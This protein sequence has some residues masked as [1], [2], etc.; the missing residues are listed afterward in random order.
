MSAL[1]HADLTRNQRRSLDRLKANLDRIRRDLTAWQD[2]LG[3]VSPRVAAQDVER[4]RADLQD[5]E[6][7]RDRLRAQLKM[8]YSCGWQDA[9]EGNAYDPATLKS[10]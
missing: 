9:I 3:Y 6:T 4:L 7:E 5:S 8:A 10:K 1:D 2:A